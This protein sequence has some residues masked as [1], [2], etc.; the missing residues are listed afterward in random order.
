MKEG[1]AEDATSRRIGQSSHPRR[2][3]TSLINFCHDLLSAWRSGLFRPSITRKPATGDFLAFWQSGV[4][5][6]LLAGASARFEAASASASAACIGKPIPSE[7]GA[8]SGRERGVEGAICPS[9]CCGLPPLLLR[10]RREM[11]DLMLTAPNGI[12]SAAPRGTSE[13][14]VF[15]KGAFC[16]SRRDDERN[17]KSPLTL[18]KKEGDAMVASLHLL[19]TPSGLFVTKRHFMRSTLFLFNQNATALRLRPF[20]VSRTFSPLIR[21]RF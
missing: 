5:C 15:G 1:S 8:K 4:G 13:T 18:W 3:L 7:S 12:R 17:C 19:M 16:V 20:G 6:W 21:Q 2:G 9:G 11:L 14:C 10:A